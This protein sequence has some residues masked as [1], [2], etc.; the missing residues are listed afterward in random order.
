M[1]RP[2][3]W[4]AAIVI[5]LVLLGLREYFDSF[6]ILY[7]AD[8]LNPKADPLRVKMT[9]D[10]TLLLYSDTRPHIGKIDGLQKGLV[11]E[12]RSRKIIEEGSHDELLSKGREYADLYETYFRH[13]ELTWEP[14]TNMKE[15]IKATE[16]L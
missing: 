3:V 11:L 13:Q 6:L 4:V 9:D 2:G 15:I 14:T 1:K 16:M 8:V 10:V 5:I 7:I 12:Y